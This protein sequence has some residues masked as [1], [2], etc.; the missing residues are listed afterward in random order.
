MKGKL[1]GVPRPKLAY[2]PSLGRVF[3]V[4]P[5]QIDGNHGGTSARNFRCRGLLISDTLSDPAEALILVPRKSPGTH[6]EFPSE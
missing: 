3:L 1:L 5:E 4:E 2:S 6:A